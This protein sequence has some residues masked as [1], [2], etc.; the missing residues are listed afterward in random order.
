[1][2]IH[3]DH[4]VA[5]TAVQRHARRNPAADT[6]ARSTP[7]RHRLDDV[8]ERTRAALEFVWRDWRIGA[9]ATVIA[10]VSAPT[11]RLC[12]PTI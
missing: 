8:A 12:S 11:A 3:V 2:S 5:N 1:M 10:A 9:G 6:P 7:W 4:G